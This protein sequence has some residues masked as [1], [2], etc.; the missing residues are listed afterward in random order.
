MRDDLALHVVCRL[1]YSS[2][3]PGVLSPQS[4]ALLD[5]K[6]KKK[7]PCPQDMHKRFLPESSKDVPV[8]K[9]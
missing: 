8:C 1:F 4:K 2:L 6:R 7:E 3:V 9:I 5:L